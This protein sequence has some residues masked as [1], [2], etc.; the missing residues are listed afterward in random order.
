MDDFTPHDMLPA[1]LAMAL[2][3]DP[4]GLAYF[5]SLPPK[6]RQALVDRAR[7]ARSKDEMQA[8]V[9]ALRS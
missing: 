9:A 4:E 5:F 2:A 8:L 3:N 6:G 7:E 1:G